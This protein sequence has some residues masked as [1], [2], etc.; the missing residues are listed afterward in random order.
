L[1][2]GEEQCLHWSVKK[3]HTGLPSCS[4]SLNLTNL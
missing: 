3:Y 4:N 1:Q 2:G